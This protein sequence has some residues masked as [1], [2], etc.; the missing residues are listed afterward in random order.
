ML[1]EEYAQ[2]AGKNIVD[3]KYNMHELVDLTRGR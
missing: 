3:V 1:I 2:L